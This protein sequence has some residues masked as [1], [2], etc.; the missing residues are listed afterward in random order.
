[1]DKINKSPFSFYDFLGYFIPGALFCYLF[2]LVFDIDTFKDIDTLKWLNFD[3]FLKL[4]VFDQSVA[5]I[6]VSYI[7]GHVI[8]Y[9]SSLT[10]EQYSIWS[11][12]YPSRY[13][14]GKNNKSYFLT[15]EEIVKRAEEKEEDIDDKQ[16]NK[17]FFI[18]LVWRI[19]LWFVVSPIAIIDFII[20]VKFQFR[21]HYTNSVDGFLKNE[22]NNKIHQFNRLQGYKLI[23]QNG[24][25]YR[26]IWHY[27]YEKFS[28]H[29]A[30]LDNYV[31]LYGFTRS[32][33]FTFCTYSWLLIFAIILQPA[34]WR[35][36]IIGIIIFA[37]LAFIFYLAFVKFYRRY[38]L[39]G[40]MC[41]LI[42]EDLIG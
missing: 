9:L 10:I 32:M 16:V 1:M 29:A 23:K 37:F 30:K 11:I 12:G 13:I 42:D 27:C 21:R 36:Y 25:F 8:N 28:V 6:I 19:G 33:S 5:F 3:F 15:R 34:L 14:L 18:S 41:L 7:I 38:T 4:E 40:F 17:E 20:G 24:D 2:V 39:E 26:P 22:I 31:A 35:Y